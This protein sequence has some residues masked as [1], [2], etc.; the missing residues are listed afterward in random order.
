MFPNRYT[1]I[2]ADF[3]KRTF[4]FFGNGWLAYY[5]KILIITSRMIALVLNPK[6]FQANRTK[7]TA[8]EGFF[9]SSSG[10]EKHP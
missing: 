10:V 7:E 2:V 3:S 9:Q 6:L 5:P 8:M 1:C 4:T